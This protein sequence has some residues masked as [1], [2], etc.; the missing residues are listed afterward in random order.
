MKKFIIILIPIFVLFFGTVNAMEYRSGQNIT[1]SLTNATDGTA[2]TG[3]ACNIS[4]SNSSGDFITYA[5][6]IDGNDGTYDWTI[7]GL[8]NN[9]IEKYLAKGNCTVD[10]NEW[11][12]W[13]YFWLVDDTTTNK[14]DYIAK[15]PS[16]YKADISSVANDV[17]TNTDRTLTQNITPNVTDFS[18]A[19]IWNYGTRTLSSFGTLIADIWAYA[20]RTLSSFAFNV[21]LNTT[22][23]DNIWDHKPR[24]LTQNITGNVTGGGNIITYDN[25]TMNIILPAE[26]IQ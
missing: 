12:T 20:T 8:G 11:I 21:S 26:A 14:T 2:Q 22:G 9:L 3:K 25:S 13:M 5:P 18:V 15:N 23:L 24:T 7:T 16:D 4:I 10:S 1:L 17:W 6:M 19:D